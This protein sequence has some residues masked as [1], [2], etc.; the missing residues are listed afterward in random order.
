MAEPSAKPARP[1]LP[2]AAELRAELHEAVQRLSF[3][4]L[5]S[6]TQWASELLAAL[7]LGGADEASPASASSVSPTL[8]RSL[9]SPVLLAK[10][11]FGMREYSRAAH[12]LQGSPAQ[13]Q[14]LHS[15]PWPVFFRSYAL[16][17]AGEKRR[18]E[19]AAEVTDPAEASRIHNTELKTLEEDLSALYREQ[20]LDGLGL[21]VY[22]I[23]LKGLELKEDARRVLLESVHA[24]PCNWSAWLDIISISADL[25]DVT[26][27]CEDLRLPP[28]WMSLFFE[29]ALQ[30]ELQRND[31]AK[32]LYVALRASF[33]ESAYIASQI[34]TCF[35]NLRN[36]DASQ[37]AF[38]ELRRRDPYRLSSLDT[39]SNIL[40]VKE[41]AAA[42]SHLARQAVKIDKYTPEAC[43]I[44]GNYYSLKGEHEKAVIY[45]RRA[46]ALN[47]HFTPAW[48]LMGHE[49]MEMKNT[50]A[51][52]DA[53]RTAVTINRRDYRAWYGLGQTYELLSLHFYALFYYRQAMSLRPD[54]ARMWCAMA[55]CYDHM[56]RKVEALKCYEKAHRC[57]DME[58]MALPRLARLHRDHGDHRQ[59]AAYYGQMLEQ[60]GHSRI[61]SSASGVRPDPS[62]LESIASVRR[63]LAGALQGGLASESVEA[64][65]FLM[66]FFAEEGRLA[67][68]EACATQLLDTTG[69]EKPQCQDPS[70]C[71]KALG[72]GA[73]GAYVSP[74]DSEITFPMNQLAS[75][76]VEADEDGWTNDIRDFQKACIDMS[77]AVGGNKWPEAGDRAPGCLLLFFRLAMQRCI[78][79]G[80]LCVRGFLVHAE[81]TCAQNQNGQ[82]E[83]TEAAA[84]ADGT[85]DCG[86]SSLSRGASTK[87]EH[88]QPVRF[89]GLSDSAKRHNEDMVSIPAGRF[90]MGERKDRV[91]F[92]QDGEGPVRPVQ[93]SSFWMDR[94][95]V[96]NEKWQDF[97][98]ETGYLTDAE[99]LGDS[100]V[101]E[102]YLSEAV[103]KTIHKKVDAVPWWLPV[104]NASW[105]QPEGID[106]AL[107]G[108]SSRYGDRWNHPVVH[109]S[110]N[111]AEAYCRWRNASLPTEAQWEYAARGGLE[112][113]LYPWGD[114]TYGNETE[115]MPRRHRM[116]IWQGAFPKENTAK[117]GYQK[118]APVDAYGPQNDWGLYNM[119]GNVWEWTGDW[120]SPVHFLTDKNKDTGLVDPTGPEIEELDEIVDMG[121]LKKDSSGQYEKIKKGGSFM[122][123]KSYCY[124]Y[125][126]CAR[127]HLTA[128]GSAH[129][130]GVRCAGEVQQKKT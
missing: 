20:K 3:A 92:P 67:E 59:A 96:S 58:R 24:F 79:L 26:G 77:D 51:A 35:Y 7:P 66:N 2:D 1:T 123:H 72:S 107:S 13:S 91:H 118:T 39:Y 73:E 83:P 62:G 117:D 19:D 28:H 47:R 74:L 46:L 68:A 54:D 109:I 127:S 38:E 48:I 9:C 93:M 112:G 81:E 18:E 17:L 71:R 103:N 22:G 70:L 76:N 53:Y 65:R 99:R 130:T 116:N 113:K 88:S 29:A 95:E 119:V 89:E 11:H 124:R 106:S 43:I 60:S 125:R 110:W 121:Y 61:V 84:M 33:P 63:P 64:L 27:R 14:E 94:F 80:A 86:C 23:V 12:V 98:R 16:Y 82:D 41:Q 87:G 97:A 102:T 57:G 129:H 21:Y 78:W 122:C 10:A 75:A 42:L 37:L 44:I 85:Q 32:D 90:H 40:F 6:S 4:E 128:D 36:F 101:A 8:P 100:F 69:S 114:T 49:F 5:H 30:L 120:Y 111:D 52:I 126:I 15:A 25:D 31:S 108:A 34:A 56:D 104:P 55:Q 50:A 105:H 45:F 115:G